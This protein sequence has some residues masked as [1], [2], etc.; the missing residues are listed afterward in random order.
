MLY[1]L[2][3]VLFLNSPK[4][5]HYI[6][7]YFLELCSLLLSLWPLFCL[8]KAFSVIISSAL[9]IFSSRAALV[10]GPSPH[11]LNPLEFWKV[12]IHCT[13]D[14]NHTSLDLFP[15]Y[16]LEGLSLLPTTQGYLDLVFTLTKTILTHATITRNQNNKFALVLAHSYTIIS[17]IT[18]E[19]E[20][21]MPY[22]C[23]VLS[24]KEQTLCYKLG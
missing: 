14:W 8:W 2:C 16:S 11:H 20:I 21:S 1:F 15:S 5:I 23:S 9:I 12:I 7:S 3:I 6:C 13:I 10:E 24:T 22:L 17:P 4:I 19:K 18:V